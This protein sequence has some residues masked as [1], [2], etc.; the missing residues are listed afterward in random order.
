MKIHT[1]VFQTLSKLYTK[2]QNPRPF[3]CIFFINKFMLYF[4]ATQLH[5][6]SLYGPLPGDMTI[7]PGLIEQVRREDIRTNLS[8]DGLEILYHCIM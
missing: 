1:H 5:S 3:R 6:L 2:F 4:I 8:I 7:F